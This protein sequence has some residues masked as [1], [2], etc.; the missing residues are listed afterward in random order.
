MPAADPQRQHVPRLQPGDLALIDQAR[1]TIHS[2]RVYA[3]NDINGETRIKRIDQPD[4]GLLILRSDNP[5]LLAEA[6]RGP[7]MNRLRIMGRSG[8]VKPHLARI[9]RRSSPNRAPECCVAASLCDLVELL[10]LQ[11][12]IAF[13][14]PPGKLGAQRPSSARDNRLKMTRPMLGHSSYIPI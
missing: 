9:A 4:Q 5:D 12:L 7:D 3:I 10:T 11:A 14:D 13:W 8:L 2:G 6:R 1:T